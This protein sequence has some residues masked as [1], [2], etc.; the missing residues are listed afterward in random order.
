MHARHALL[1][2]LLAALSAPALRASPGEDGPTPGAPGLGD[3]Y[4]PTLGNGGYD[5]LHYDL[6]L[7]I[8][9]E[10]GAVE[11]ALA[12]RA[13]ATQALSAF[14][15]DFL[16]PEVLGV[17][18]DGQGAAFARAEGE[19]VITPQQPL[20]LGQEFTAGVRYAGLPARVVDPGV[21]FIQEGIGWV[22]LPD[23]TIVV[24][25]EPSG[26]RGFVP[27]NDHPLDK[28]TWTITL[29]VDE[30]WVAAANGVLKDKRTEGGK[31]TSRF[32]MDDPM[33]SYLATVCVGDFDVETGEGPNGLPLTHYFYKEP[34]AKKRERARRAFARTSDQ[35]AFFSE[36]FGPYPFD[37]FGGVLIDEGLGGALETQTLV[38]YT[39]GADEGTIAHELAH[40]WTGN[41]V[42]PASWE[43]LWLNEGFA[44]YASWLWREH[45][46]GAEAYL[47]RVGQSYRAVRGMGPPGKTGP[48]IFQRS[49]YD[50]GA[51]TLHALRVELGDETFF[52]VL[53]AWPERHKG[54]VVTT[55][56][57]RAL[58][59]E[60][61]GKDLKAFFQAWIYD[62]RCPVVPEFEPP[63]GE[64]DGAAK[65][66]E[67]PPK[68]PKDG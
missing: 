27:C 50:R 2:A 18:V 25:S 23:K 59:E 61:S 22:R 53:R 48:V 11:G 42:S 64:E 24:M 47:K 52:R 17:E 8:D 4:Y 36:V 32:E 33:A 51:W 7:A 30:P 60:L 5:A 46:K 67:E 9:V 15:L 14:D 63:P 10:T 56:D 21:P 58:C 68:P 28:A 19:L 39:G 29:V 44:T 66:G 34:D 65:E 6:H 41:S 62:E 3:P 12:L 16:G 20:A 38:V 40:Q 55:A 13:R 54:G 26:A 49:V 45:D 35:I 37:C 57:F 31:T 1:L 43:H